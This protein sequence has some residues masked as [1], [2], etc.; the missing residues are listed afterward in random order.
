MRK[1]GLLILLVLFVSGLFFSYFLI[2]P[3]FN[4]LSGFLSKSEQV[5]ANILLV[6]GWIPDYAVKK[7]YEEY[8]NNGYEFIITTGLKSTSSYFE[9][10]E[11]GYLIFYPGNRFYG[12][13]EYATHSITVH[14]YSELGGENRAH[15]NLYIN[16]ALEA[17]FFAGK[18]K[19][20]YGITWNGKLS[21]IDSILVQFT[22]DDKGDFGD[23]NLYVKEIIVDNKITIPYPYNSEFDASKLDGKRRIINNF[24][25]NAELVR[26]KLVSMGIDSTR[27]IAAPCERVRVNRT[28]TS[29]LAFR[30]WLRTSKINVNGINIITVGMHARRTWMTY[31]KILNEKY[32]IGII[33]IP[34]YTYNHSRLSKVL[35]ALRE[36]LGIIYY[37]IILIPY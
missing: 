5:K 29:A 15:F 27:V 16:N 20:K 37:W 6:E 8:R 1:K 28:L 7:A 34:E 9:L 12:L 4:Y 23:R 31:N 2:K 25:S 11:D 35:K 24:N 3:A 22:N 30:D 14:A 10:S 36:T 17:D 13:S 18:R 32:Q 26:N 19:E 21:D 33:S